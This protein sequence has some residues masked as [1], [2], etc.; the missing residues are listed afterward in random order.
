[1]ILPRG[2]HNEHGDESANHEPEID[3]EVGRQNKPSVTVAFLKLSGR[4]RRTD[5]AGRTVEE[6]M[7]SIPGWGC[8]SPLLLSANT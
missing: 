1:M 2:K 3:L 7:S 8:K 5:R 4:L 6:M